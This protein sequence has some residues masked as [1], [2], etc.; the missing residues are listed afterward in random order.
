MANSAIKLL[1]DDQLLQKFKKQALEH[2]KKFD[3]Q[4]ILPMYEELYESVLKP[5]VV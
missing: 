1:S 5:A 3:M 4:A 2:A